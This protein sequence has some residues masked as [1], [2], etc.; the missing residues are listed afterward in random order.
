MNDVCFKLNDYPWAFIIQLRI[1][2]YATRNARRVQMKH[3]F[4]CS[5]LSVNLKMETNETKLSFIIIE[6]VKGTS[7]TLNKLSICRKYGFNYKTW[8]HG[9]LL[10][11]HTVPVGNAYY[12]QSF[13]PLPQK[14]MYQVSNSSISQSQNILTQGMLKEC[15]RLEQCLQNIIKCPSVNFCIGYTI[16][17]CT[18]IRV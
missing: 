2:S 6:Y 12:K 18:A 17:Q 15:L 13:L 1:E 9:Q 16:I 10:I 11:S 7:L 3:S 4:W 8:Q 5:L 14:V